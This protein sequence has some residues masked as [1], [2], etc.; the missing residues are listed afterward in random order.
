MDE[1]PTREQLMAFDIR[2][3]WRRGYIEGFRVALLATK[4]QMNAQAWD[5]LSLWVQTELVKW[6]FG[7][8]D[9]DAK[10]PQPP[11]EHVDD[12]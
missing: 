11:T 1:V 6:R 3:A 5:E 7:P 10:P 9:K 8:I 12:I 2:R 4:G